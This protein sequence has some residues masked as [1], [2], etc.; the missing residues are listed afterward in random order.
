MRIRTSLPVGLGVSMMVSQSGASNLTRD[1]RRINA[2]AFV[3]QTNS[4]LFFVAYIGQFTCHGNKAAHRDC[5]RA[6]RRIDMR[7]SRQPCRIGRQ[8]FEALTQHFPALAERRCRDLLEGT[9][10]AGLGG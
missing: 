9:A 6:S 4:G 5:L 8:R 3:P 10:L 2:M 1:W 7:C